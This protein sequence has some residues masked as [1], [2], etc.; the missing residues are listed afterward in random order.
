MVSEKFY[1]RLMG[2]EAH[3]LLDWFRQVELIDSKIKEFHFDLAQEQIFI[4][5]NQIS[6]NSTYFIGRPVVGT[7]RSLDGHFELKEFNL[8]QKKFR[9]LQSENWSK[10]IQE[11]ELFEKNLSLNKDFRPILKLERVGIE[12][13]NFEIGFFFN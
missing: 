1:L 13:I 2:H 8:D 6:L 7:K 4:C 12:K 11:L 9:K 10:V 3:N 5:L